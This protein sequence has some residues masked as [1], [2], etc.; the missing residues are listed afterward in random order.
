MHASEWIVDFTKDISQIYAE[1]IGIE[2]ISQGPSSGS[3]HHSFWEYGYDAVFYA[4][5][6]FND[7][8]HSSDD[9]IDQMNINLCNSILT[10]YPCNP[11]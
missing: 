2:L 4:E 3:D 11:C 6:N 9:T 1:Y 8:Y 10:T 5:F 7:Y